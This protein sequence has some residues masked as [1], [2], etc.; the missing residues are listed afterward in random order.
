MWLVSPLTVMQ[1]MD[2]EMDKLKAKARRRVLA[3]QQDKFHK[4]FDRLIH[5]L[6]KQAVSARGWQGG[7]GWCVGDGAA[8]GAADGAGQR[9]RAINRAQ[10]RR[11]RRPQR[12][13]GERDHRP[14]PRRA[15]RR[16]RRLQ[17]GGGA[18][19]PAVGGSAACCVR[20]KGG[21][22]LYRACVCVCVCAAA[23]SAPV[24]QQPL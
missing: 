2:N 13:V 16:L 14:C 5:K 7:G 18:P 10:R 11:R 8:T 9:A 4:R 21:A 15:Q 19:P 17:Q 23:S 3:K 22:G 20:D 6:D 1:V 12:G 24:R